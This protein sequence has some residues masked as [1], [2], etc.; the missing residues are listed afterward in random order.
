MRRLNMDIALLDLLEE[1]K[2]RRQFD[3][4]D[5]G[6]ESFGHARLNEMPLDI[7]SWKPR[8][9]S[10][11]SIWRVSGLSA[12]ISTRVEWI[13][14]TEIE[15]RNSTLRT[16]GLNSIKVRASQS[17]S[18]KCRC[19]KAIKLTSVC[20]EALIIR[21]EVLGRWAMVYSQAAFFLFRLPHFLH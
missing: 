6:V 17:V 4:A 13:Q 2:K 8:G 18:W 20:A 19:P 14:Q 10:P 5:W 21:L 1:T 16:V 3:F 9:E 12:V 11:T 7:W 15:T